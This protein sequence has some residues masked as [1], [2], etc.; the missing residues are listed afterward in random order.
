MKLGCGRWKGDPKPVPYAS[1]R[2][3]PELPEGIGGP[4]ARPARAADKPG[5][6]GEAEGGGRMKISRALKALQAFGEIVVSLVVSP[7]VFDIVNAQ[8]REKQI[9]KMLDDP[10]VKEV[11]IKEGMFTT[12]TE[13]VLASPKS[14]GD[15]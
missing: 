13:I 15:G 2:P 6:A 5:D 8:E 12:K 1:C 14:E 7:I 10:Y 9:K 11:K 4:G 3:H